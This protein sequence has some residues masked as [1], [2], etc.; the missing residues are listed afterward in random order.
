MARKSPERAAIELLS[1]HTH[2]EQKH[3]AGK[4]LV[5]ADIG[6]RP[7]SAG[8]LVER[9]KARWVTPPPEPAPAE[10]LITTENTGE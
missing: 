9:G 3:P 5:L 1:E 4:T 6:M 7:A 2:G 10:T 8:W